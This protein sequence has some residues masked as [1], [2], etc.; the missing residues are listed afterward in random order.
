LEVIELG[1]GRAVVIF[2]TLFGNTEKIAKALAKGI[3]QNGVQVDCLNIKD[4][5]VD[6]LGQYSLIVIGAPTQMF[7]ASRTMK[8]FLSR[9]KG[10]SFADRFGFAFDTKL[11]SRLSGSAA[12]FIE[13]ELDDIGL[14][15]VAPR[16]SAIVFQVKGG[17]KTTARL[18]E[19]EEERFVGIGVVIGKTLIAKRPLTAAPTI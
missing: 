5:D 4:V 19:G 11:D 3:G 1:S 12:K 18:K 16:E 15:I 14:R 10:R 8:A 17:G 7:T 13:H 6:N 9:L 2:D